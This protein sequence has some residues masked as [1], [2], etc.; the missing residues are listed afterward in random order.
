MAYLPPQ[1]T[2][3]RAR[4][5]SPSRCPLP[6][7]LSELLA[8]AV[9]DAR[10]LNSDSY[11]PHSGNWHFPKPEGVCEVCLA[12][13]VIAVS[14]RISHLVFSVP[15]DFLPSVRRKL[16]CID[17]MR[18]G[19]WNHAF[20]MLHDRTAPPAICLQ[21]NTLPTPSQAS[22]QSWADFKT[23]LESLDSIIPK[24]RMIESLTGAD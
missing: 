16:H 24:L 22:F 12:G 19:L 18:C 23:H 5:L 9:R 15:N 10:Q 3:R 6:N 20:L 2:V 14:L 13:S 17:Y 11:I 21:L 1:R 8:V 4:S 7:S